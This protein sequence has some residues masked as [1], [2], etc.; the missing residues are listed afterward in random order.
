MRSRLPANTAPALVAAGLFFACWGLIHHGFYSNGVLTDLPTYTTYGEQMRHGHVPYRD[1][2]VE[3]P[4]GALPV[5][6]APAF[7]ANYAFVFGWL[8]AACGVAMVLVVAAATRSRFALGFV[9]ISP[10][11]V[12]SL[13]PTR[14]DL[15]PVALL[16]AAVVALAGRRDRLGFA[17][18]GAATV[19]KAFPVVVLPVALIWV[20]RRRGREATI[21]AAAIFAGVVAVVVAPFFAESPSGLWQSVSGQ[22]SRPLQI[23]TLPAAV[24]ML[25]G[26]PTV[27]N[28]H[29]S[30]N[31]IHLDAVAACL[32]VV[33]LLAFAALWFA[34]T[35][36]TVDRER[37]VQGAAAS[38]AIF[39][40]CGKVLS[41]QYLI[42]LVPL[43]ALLE[44][45]KS[46]EH[47]SELQSH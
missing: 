14:F 44:G 12:G 3:Y 33:E 13:Y 5:F 30:F 32:S 24:A 37:F 36:G 22:F 11:L 31:L 27:A 8:M 45:R 35:R 15:W 34:L 4:P 6:L 20:Y 18:L 19:V 29:G 26:H 38:V 46:E 1:F 16:G 41:P 25:V 39:V 2:R 9:A 10:L 43:V 7:F 42:W 21:Q 17:L 47:T 23:E 40:A 28:T